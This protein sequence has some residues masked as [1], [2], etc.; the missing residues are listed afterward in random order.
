MDGKRLMK[1]LTS[2]GDSQTDYTASY[3]V[4]ASDTW[5]SVL[6]KMLGTGWQGR[7]FGISGDTSTQALARTDVLFQYDNPTIAVIAIGV[8]DPGASITTATSQANIQALIM[9]AKHKA[10]GR[11]AGLGTGVTAATASTLP[12]NGRLGERYVVLSDTSTTGGAAAYHSSH[13]ATIT[14]TV[15][16]DTNGQK[17]AVWENRYPLAGEAGWGRVAKT[18]AA[19]TLGASKIVVVP[20]PYRNFTTGGD[21]PS[22]PDATNATLR[23]AISA[24]VALEAVN[25]GGSPTVIYSD[26]YNFMKARIQAGTDLD[27]SAV[28]YDQTRSWH[29]ALNNQHFSSY[30][31]L[32][33]ALKLY[34]DILANWP[35]VV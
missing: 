29:Y 25:V 33:L 19:P 31:H 16:A 35:S 22:T 18:G 23:G 13:A 15:T 10:V 27:F 8:N 21:T 24:A 34:L 17:L 3:G 7:G 4:R 1:T 9:A 32:L 28:A 30:G 12:A 6:A 5:T 14:G 11:G 2:I 20:P 26:L